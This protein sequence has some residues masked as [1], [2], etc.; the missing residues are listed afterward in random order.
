MP[1]ITMCPGFD[2]PKMKTCYRHMASPSQRQSFF[3]NSPWKDTAITQKKVTT[4]TLRG[5]SIND[6][7][8]DHYVEYTNEDKKH[9]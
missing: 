6:F 9:K 8:C 7:R 4:K 3:M 1:D 2:C 5:P